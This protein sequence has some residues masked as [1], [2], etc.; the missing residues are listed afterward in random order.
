M[1]QEGPR[2]KTYPAD[3]TD[4]PWEILDRCSLPHAPSMEVVPA[5]STCAK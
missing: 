5:Q 4:E 2:R 3:L 1:S